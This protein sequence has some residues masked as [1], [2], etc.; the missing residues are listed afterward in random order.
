MSV[1]GFPP[2]GGAFTTVR[3]RF[4][5]LDG[6]WIFSVDIIFRHSSAPCTYPSK[7]INSQQNSLNW[8]KWAKIWR[9]LWYKVH[10]LEK[11]TPSPVVWLGLISVVS[12]KKNSRTHP[13][14]FTEKIRVT[15]YFPGPQCESNS[16]PVLCFESPRSTAGPSIDTAVAS[17]LRNNL[18]HIEMT[19]C[20]I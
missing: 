8:S 1:P 11:S 5:L 16:G 9:F 18:F 14:P 4:R 12:W 19:G 3:P 20:M 6:S 10:R 17:G 7:C 15:I 13:F 2:Q